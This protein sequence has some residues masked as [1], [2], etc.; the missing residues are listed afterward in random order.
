[1]KNKPLIDDNFFPF[2]I[3]M[4]NKNCLI[5]GGGKIALRKANTLLKMGAKVTVISQEI[6]VDE[7]FSLPITIEIRSF[8]P[9]IIRKNYFLVIA[10]TNN[11]IINEE[12]VNICF[13]LG[14]L[15]NNITSKEYMDLRF[16]SVINEKDYQ[17]GISGKGNP[18]K[19]I[20][21]KNVIKNIDFNNIL[22]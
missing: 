4:S 6:L 5:I 8:S 13:N 14:I 10:G 7:F 16:S 15:V 17:I 20:M 21:I 12:I 22:E 18:K 2:F 19:S 11:I 1:M 9:E 3:N